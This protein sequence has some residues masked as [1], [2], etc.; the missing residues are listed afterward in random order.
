MTR[1]TPLF[2]LL[3]IQAAVTVAA[4]A[5]HRRVVPEL[6]AGA[7]EASF[8]VR[9]ALSRWFVPSCAVVGAAVTLIALVATSGRRRL[10]LVA[11]G[12][13]LAALPPAV[14]V[15]AAYAALLAG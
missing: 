5:F 9:I 6:A 4:L 14:A 13:T 10:S 8:A 2:S 1:R 12:V 7:P 15:L 3:V 11:A